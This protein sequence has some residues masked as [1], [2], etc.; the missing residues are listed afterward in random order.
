MLNNIQVSIKTRKFNF[1]IKITAFLKIFK[2]VL[3]FF[4]TEVIFKT[5]FLQLVEQV[6]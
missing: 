2:L 3:I 6:S 5:I 1:H 4:C